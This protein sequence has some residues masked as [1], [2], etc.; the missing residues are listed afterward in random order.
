MRFRVQGSKGFIQFLLYAYE[1]I[2]GWFVAL[3]CGDSV[4][5]KQ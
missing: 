2:L 3:Q 4:H 5:G 1:V